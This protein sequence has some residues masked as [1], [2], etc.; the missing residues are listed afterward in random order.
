V[1]R[2]RLET[3]M[4]EICSTNTDDKQQQR[5]NS[6]CRDRKGVKPATGGSSEIWRKDNDA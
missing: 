2:Q 4:Q 1:V 5:L 3:P 6:S